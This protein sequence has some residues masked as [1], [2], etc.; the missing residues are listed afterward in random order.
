MHYIGLISGTS[1]DAIDCALVDITESG[2]S[3]VDYQQ[4]PLDRGIKHQLIP[5]N[6]KTSLEKTAALDV[7]LGE[8]FAEAANAI[9]HV[10]RIEKEQIR[11]IGCHGQTIY[12]RTAGT[13]HTSIQ[14]GDAN[15]IA[16][17]TGIDTVSDF[18][19][20]DMALGGQGAPFAP[21]IHEIL[22]R[23][24]RKDTV[25][26]NIGGMANITILPS[27][28]GGR[29]VTGFDT[30]PGN[31]LLDEWTR[32]HQKLDYDSDGNWA[33]FGTADRD[34]LDLMLAYHYFSLPPPKSTG[35]DEFNL[36]WLKNQLEMYKVKLSNVNVQTT[37]VELTAV[38]IGNMIDQ[39]AS[40]AEDVILCG[41]GA[42]NRYLMERLACRL[43]GRNLKTT[44]DYGYNPDAIEA[45]CFAW[46]AKLRMD[47][48]AVP[49]SS[50]TGAARDAVLGAIYSSGVQV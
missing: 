9:C 4:Y 40:A 27:G 28:Q 22:F 34:L 30:G 49:V 15:I 17:R 42:H 47:N 23:Q 50:V 33:K 5:I 32:L 38:S 25:V 44:Q 13:A 18:R 41:G 14:I 19:R 35:R 29:S 6:D 31:V 11:A 1:M 37:L 43:E 26:V 12:H 46:L 10:N 2:I 48:L 20:M 8:L 24:D 21:V 3:L 45:M 16:A 7:A 39:H 36:N